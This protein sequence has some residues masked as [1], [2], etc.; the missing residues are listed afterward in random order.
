[1]VDERSEWHHLCERESWRKKGVRFRHDGTT[2]LAPRGDGFCI[3]YQSPLPA[4]R[5]LSP[6]SVDV[7]P[8]A[9]EAKLEVNGEGIIVV[10]RWYLLD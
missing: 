10:W 8:A 7:F 6:P 2:T 5:P 9:A 3:T 4:F 1:M